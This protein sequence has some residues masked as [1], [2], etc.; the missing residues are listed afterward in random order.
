MKKIY[1]LLLPINIADIY[2]SIKCIYH[3]SID[4][5]LPKINRQHSM[6]ALQKE[7][8]FLLKKK[9]QWILPTTMLASLVIQNSYV[10]DFHM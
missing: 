4:S 6:L 10:S 8:T 2:V 9:L 7:I 5:C 1:A 3:P